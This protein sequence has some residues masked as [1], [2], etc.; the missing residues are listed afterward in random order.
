MIYEPNKFKQK[1]LTLLKSDYGVELYDYNENFVRI[2]F[3]HL[4]SVYNAFCSAFYDDETS[5]NWQYAAHNK[6]VES[7]VKWI[8]A[9]CV[10]CFHDGK[11]VDFVKSEFEYFK[12]RS[13]AVFAAKYSIE[14]D[15]HVFND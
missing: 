15:L 2:S 11:H 13:A 10:K 7:A 6:K 8:T 3:Y 12:E 5:V 1:M 4:G 9:F 14:T